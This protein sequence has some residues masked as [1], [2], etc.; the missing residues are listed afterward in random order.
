M[1]DLK[2][3]KKKHLLVKGKIILYG[4]LVL[5]KECVFEKCNVKYLDNVFNG[6]YKWQRA[7]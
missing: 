1:T 7:S 2:K 3:K 6:T 4:K 5:W